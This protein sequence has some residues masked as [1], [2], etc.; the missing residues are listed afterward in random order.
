MYQIIFFLHVLSAILMGFY[1]LLP[2]LIKS[3]AGLPK[4]AQAGFAGALQ[5][6]NKM[7]QYILI[8]AFLS[9]GYMVSKVNV[10]VLWMVVSILLFLVIGAMA[11]MMTKPIKRWIEHVNSAQSAEDELRKLN[12]FSTIAGL[13]FLIMTVIMI[14]PGLL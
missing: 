10:S 5:V 1:L 13:S 9:G 6:L 11:G 2:F 14:F 4:P 7:G 3:A 8:V 12:S